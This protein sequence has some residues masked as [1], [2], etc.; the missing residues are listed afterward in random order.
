[1]ENVRRELAERYIEPN[2]RLAA[3][4]GPSFPMWAR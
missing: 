3:L 4:L 2:K 1:M